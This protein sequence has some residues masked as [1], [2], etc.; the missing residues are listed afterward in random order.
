[1][2]W[3]SVVESSK[4]LNKGSRLG[5]YP[6]DSLGSL[7]IS[8]EGIPSVPLTG[9]LDLLFARWFSIPLTVPWRCRFDFV[10]GSNLSYT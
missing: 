2:L 8:I 4:V 9:R 1:M 10:D 7:L 5:S 6:S 3:I